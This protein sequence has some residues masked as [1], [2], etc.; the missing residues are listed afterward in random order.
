PRNT[1]SPLNVCSGTLAGS[2]PSERASAARGPG[3]TGAVAGPGG[4]EGVA[5]GV[6][7]GSLS[8]AAL[9][10][11]GL[12]LLGVVLTLGLTR[13]EMAE[14]IGTTQETTI[15]L[16]SRFK[17]KGYLRLDKRTIVLADI[18][19]LLKVARLSL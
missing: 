10:G 14:M 12:G 6:E 11:L 1:A 13:E 18:P 9:L 2:Q 8:D 7:M 3:S 17:Q 15:R 4:L 5:I 16:L 19:G